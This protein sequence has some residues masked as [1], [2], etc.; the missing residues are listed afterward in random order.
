MPQ[1][2][3]DDLAAYP[4]VNEAWY[5]FD[6]TIHAPLG[7]TALS[8]DDLIYT[9]G[10]IG[11]TEPVITATDFGGTSATQKARVRLTLPPEYVAG[12]TLTLRVNGKTGTTVAD[13]SST[14]D[15]NVYRRLPPLSTSARR[16]LKAST[17]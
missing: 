13:T 3:Q 8:A 10:S 15:F 14:V 5:L 2:T 16:P 12:E 4:I 17:A 7:A 11:T 1:L 9:L 6:S